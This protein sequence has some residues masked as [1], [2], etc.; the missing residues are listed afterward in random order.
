VTLPINETDPVKRIY[1]C[2]QNIEALKDSLITTFFALM[3]NIVGLLPAWLNRLILHD[4]VFP[5]GIWNF[6]GGLELV[7]GDFERK[8]HP[9]IDVFYV[10]GLAFGNLGNKKFSSV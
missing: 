4:A 2:H 5:T 8:Q 3:I 9:I 1:E 10:A 7:H 6:P